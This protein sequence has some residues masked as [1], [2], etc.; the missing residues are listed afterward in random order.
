MPTTNW[1]TVWDPVSAKLLALL[2]NPQINGV[3]DKIHG[4][5]SVTYPYTLG[6]DRNVNQY[7][8]YI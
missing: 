4:K 3:I 1:V 2:L 5:T 8:V 7:I 6:K